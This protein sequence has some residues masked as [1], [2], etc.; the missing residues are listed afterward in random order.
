MVVNM[1]YHVFEFLCMNC[2]ACQGFIVM[3][4]RLRKQCRINMIHFVKIKYIV[5]KKKGQL[6]RPDGKIKKQALTWVVNV[7]IV[8]PKVLL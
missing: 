6:F 1:R 3:C 7:Q 8:A 4:E 2:L 5:K